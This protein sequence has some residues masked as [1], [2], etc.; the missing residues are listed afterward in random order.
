MVEYARRIGRVQGSVIR[1]IFKMM[2]DPRII[3]LGGGSPAAESY[4]LADI[5]AIS[6]ELLRDQ[7]IAMLE[8]GQTTGYAPLREAYLEHL[9]LPKGIEAEPQNVVCLTGSSQGI[10]LAFDVFLDP[11]DTVL[12]ENP[13]FL[14]PLNLLRKA[15]DNIIGLAMDEQGLIIEDLVEKVKKYR[16]KM[17][18]T[19]PTF[20]N[21]SG[22]SLCAK[23]RQ[24]VAELAAEYDFV[25]LE[26]D[27][28]A[29]IRFRGAKLPPIKSFDTA[30]HV[31]MLNSF[32]KTI[33]P[34]LRVGAAVA[35]R[36]W[37]AK[38]ELVKQGADT[39]TA[40]LP[41]AICAE[42]LRRGLLPAH[43]RHI[44]PIYEERYQALERGI[45]EHF[46]ADTVYTRPDGGMFVCARLPGRD[47]AQL[48]RRAVSE[49]EVAFIPG[50]PFCVEPGEGADCFRLNFSGSAP[51][52]I[53]TACERLGRLF[54]MA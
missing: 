38:L 13:T 41:Q 44:A 8:Y 5:L 36:E 40:T 45:R 52:R 24:R 7:G 12:V 51:E 23:R 34:G 18:Y 30:E 43:L 16:P 37:A 31:I 10:F 25:V 49:Y 39:H 1:E 26:D 21:P 19:I 14:A 46:P 9:V 15:Q 33:A 3:S 32:S 50:A 29:E 53:A 22:R 6:D 11:G 42:F 35:R 20:Q 28:Y 27:P 4:P 54:A 48:N 17:L 47:M 2:A